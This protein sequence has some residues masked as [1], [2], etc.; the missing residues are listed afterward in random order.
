MF[1]KYEM[2]ETIAKTLPGN[3]YIYE[4]HTFVAKFN[5]VLTET[6]IIVYKIGWLMLFGV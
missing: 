2:I 5:Q 3:E 6:F 1:G 4:S